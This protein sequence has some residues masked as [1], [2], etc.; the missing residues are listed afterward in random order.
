MA[1]DFK[2]IA[3]DLKVIEG[4]SCNNISK[5]C[6]VSE[7]FHSLKHINERFEGVKFYEWIC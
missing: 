2:G 3:F 1:D 6:K 4:S 7:S 5:A